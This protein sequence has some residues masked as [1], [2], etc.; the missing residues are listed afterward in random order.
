MRKTG[1]GKL[2]LNFTIQLVDSNI[3]LTYNT[4]DIGCE[5]HLVN[6]FFAV[7]PFGIASPK[8]IAD[9]YTKAAG[10]K[11][12]FFHHPKSRAPIGT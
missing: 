2:K 6:S 8:N 4:L 12:G 1:C 5:K 3:Y 9:I 10:I 7:L 11:F